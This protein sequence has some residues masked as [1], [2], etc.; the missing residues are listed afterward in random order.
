MRGSWMRGRRGVRQQK[1]S[2]RFPLI[3]TSTTAVKSLLAERAHRKVLLLASRQ[4]LLDL[5]LAELPEVAAQGLPERLGG[6][7]GIGVRT[8][9]RLGDDLVDHPELE[10]VVGR[11]LE[12]LGGALALARVLPQN[13]GASLGRDYRVHG[14]LE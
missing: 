5:D 10:Q 7:V 14:V 2:L 11:E 12:R 8:P 6:G 1:Y 9:R 4:Q 13:G 3:R